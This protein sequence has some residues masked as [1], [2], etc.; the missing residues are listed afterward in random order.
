M[1]FTPAKIPIFSQHESQQLREMTPPTLQ[2][3]DNMKSRL[4]TRLHTMDVD[5]LLHLH[6][7]SQNSQTHLFWHTIVIILISFLILLGI[8]YVFIRAY[9]DKLKCYTVKTPDTEC[10]KSPQTSTQQPQAEPR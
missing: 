3:L 7:T 9:L 6:R 5:S 2:K 10:N 8:L 4:A 1:E